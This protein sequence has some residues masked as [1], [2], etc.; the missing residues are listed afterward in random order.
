VRVAVRGDAEPDEVWDRFTTPARWSSW[1]PHIRAVTCADARV[2]TGTRGHVHGP[3]GLRLPFVVDAVDHPGRTWT[4]TVGRAIRV[5]MVHGVE[6]ADGGSRAW[7]RL[8]ALLGVP[9][10]P[11]LRWALARLV[12]GAN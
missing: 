5:T 12:R 2:V 8:P 7:A 6:H 3:M 4:W 11:L 9:Y 1:A 10:L